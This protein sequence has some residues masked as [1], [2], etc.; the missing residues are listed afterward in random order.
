MLKNHS[1]FT[2]LTCALDNG[3]EPHFLDNNDPQR[4]AFELFKP[5]G[6]I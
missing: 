3:I 4:S 2:L 5:T 6:L 1:E